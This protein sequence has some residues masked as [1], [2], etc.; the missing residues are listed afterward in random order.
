MS[1]QESAGLEAIAAVETV[2]KFGGRDV[3]IRPLKVGQLPP[4]ARAIKPVLPFVAHAFTEGGLSAAFVV[5]VIAEHGEQVI[6]AVSVASGVPAA[7][8]SDA[9]PEDFLPLVTTV[10]NVNKD[11]FVRLLSKARQAAAE[12]PASGDGQTPSSA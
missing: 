3:A 9:D 1:A 12:S 11:F 4:F 5:E 8:I 7:E 6:E 2:I 10:L